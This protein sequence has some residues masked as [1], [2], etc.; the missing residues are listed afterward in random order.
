MSAPRV[1]GARGALGS[2]PAAGFSSPT[3]SVV[4]HLNVLWS[5]YGALQ[6]NKRQWKSSCNGNFSEFQL[7]KDG[8][9]TNV[10][11]CIFW[12]FELLS[13]DGSVM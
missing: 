13:D 7:S 8:P 11:T 12:R 3:L 10:S 9:L 1:F 6:F 2:A 5:F 4:W